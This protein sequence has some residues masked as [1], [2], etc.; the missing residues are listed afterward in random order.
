M[1]FLFNFVSRVPKNEPNRH[2]WIEK[3]E[4]H[5]IFDYSCSKFFICE[6]HFDTE[7][8]KRGARIY[9]KKDA[10]P[11]KFRIYSDTVTTNLSIEPVNLWDLPVVISPTTR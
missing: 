2:I 9:L 7:D 8:I 4:K 6:E 10:L 3:I 1:D 11:Q 5:Q